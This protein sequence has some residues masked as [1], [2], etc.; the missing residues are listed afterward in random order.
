M[1]QDM[2]MVLQRSKILLVEDDS[3]DV[4]IMRGLLGDRWDGPFDLV[5]AETL[6][7]ALRHCARGGIDVILLDLTLPDSQGLETF[8][9]MHA[10]AGEVPIVVLTGVQDERI[11][12]KAVQAGAEDYLVKGQVDDQLLV[13]SLRYAIERNRRHRIERE[14]QSASEEFRLAQ[15]IQKRLFP[16]EPPQVEGFDIGAALYPATATAGDYFDYIPMRDGRLAVVIGDVTGHG[17]GP[18]LLMAETRAVLRALVEVYNDLGD[19]LTRANHVLVGDTDDSHFVTLTLAALDPRTLS[20]A[21]AGAGQRGY[22]LEPDGKT[23]ILDSTSLPLG[24]NENMTALCSPLVSLEPGQIIA[25]FTDGVV[26]AESPGLGR[27]GAQRALDLI[28]K[29]RHRSA[30]D[31]VKSLHQQIVEFCY[32]RPQA[33]DITIVVIKIV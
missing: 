9:I 20:L 27:Y 25:L 10:E 23:K 7:V 32:H 19:I 4:W 33:D 8:L 28:H 3:D 16:N 15:Q 31:I 1:R 29:Q 13:R 26:E 5:H 6:T 21:Y 22:L 11:G 18:A 17:M 30:A 12:V 14:L 24:I 2:G